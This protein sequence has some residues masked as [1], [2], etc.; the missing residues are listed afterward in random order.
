MLKP[1][2][3]ALKVQLFLQLT[4]LI[5]RYSQE[6]LPKKPQNAALFILG[7]YHGVSR[8]CIGGKIVLGAMLQGRWQM[9]ALAR[10]LREI[11]F[12]DGRIFLSELP[13]FGVGQR[14][15]SGNAFVR[16]A[17]FWIHRRRTCCLRRVGDTLR[18]HT[19]STQIIIYSF[20]KS[21]ITHSKLQASDI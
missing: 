12:P 18:L 16:E 1:D 14:R 3:M 21:E 2:T 5:I 20:L 9:W 15:S 13:C 6:S 19:K 4:V 7:E 10:R 17:S 8:L 11:W